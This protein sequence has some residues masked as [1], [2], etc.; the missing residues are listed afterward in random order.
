[1]KITDLK[2]KEGKIESPLEDMDSFRKEMKS[3][4]KEGDSVLEQNPSVTVTLIKT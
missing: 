3:N 4:Y 1:M 2:K